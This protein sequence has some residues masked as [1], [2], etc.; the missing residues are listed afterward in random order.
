MVRVVDALKAERG[1]TEVGIDMDVKPMAVTVR[2]D[3][4]ATNAKRIG[5]AAKR[6]MQTDLRNPAPVKVIYEKQ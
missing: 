1:V 3:P 2:F 4:Q 6:A 5:K